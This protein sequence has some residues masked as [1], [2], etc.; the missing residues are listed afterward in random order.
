MTIDP[1]GIDALAA[2]L[3]DPAFF[4]EPDFAALLAHLRA[5]ESVR[6]CQ[7]WPQR[8]FWAVTRHADIK[9]ALEQPHLLSS[10]AAG[11]IIPADPDLHRGD[12]DAMGFGVMLTNTDPPHH[13]TLRRIFSRFFSGPQV[14]RLEGHCQQIVDG[15]LAEL[16]G[17]DSFD[18]VGDVA[19]PLPARLICQ[20]LGVPREDWPFIFQYAN[21]FASFADPALQLGATPGET[22]MIAMR[23]T[24]DYVAE[25]VDRRRTDP[26]DD[27]CSMAALSEVSPAEAAWNAWAVLAAG[28]ETSR[29]AIS[30]GLLA[31][32]EHPEQAAMLRADR[33]LW[34]PA[35]E[36]MFRWSNPA[37]AILRV[38]CEDIE[39]A[40]QPIARGD[41]V[42][43]F[44]ESA[45]RDERVFDDPFRFDI[46]RRRNP[47]M[48]FG[49]GIHNCIGR[50]LAGLEVRVM[51]RTMLDR[52][53][54][55]ELAGPL[56]RG[57]S[58]IAKGLTR[59]PVKVAWA[60]PQRDSA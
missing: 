35:V 56:E 31:L 58:T 51:I 3:A 36:E 20:L 11:N 13:S 49:F 34:L 54:R 44:I 43:L 18:F 19:A 32:I 45:N 47:H 1:H 8:G 2:R 39:I 40:G 4:L 52:T 38:A 5:E 27:L 48:S 16:D 14:A 9:W 25:L 60:E 41:W 29:N 23:T 12:R 26:R 30:G 17:R 24:F 59:M 7:P 42:V 6:W 55:I 21:S 37:T 33:R 50:M 53:D 15:I 28:F 22:F 10:E 57:A 46:Q